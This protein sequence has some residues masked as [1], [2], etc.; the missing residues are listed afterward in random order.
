MPSGL[1][2]YTPPNVVP[3]QRV[4]A[5]TSA[6]FAG[7]P[8]S[9]SASAPTVTVTDSSGSPLAG[10][11]LACDIVEGN[12]TV[13]IAHPVAGANGEGNCGRWQLG[14]AAG[15]NILRVSVAGAALQRSGDPANY[16]NFLGSWNSI[17]RSAS[18]R[19]RHDRR[20]YV[21]RTTEPKAQRRGIS[22]QASTRWTRTMYMQFSTLFGS[23]TAR[24]TLPLG[25]ALFGPPRPASSSGASRIQASR[26]RT[27]GSSQAGTQRQLADG[28]VQQTSI[29]PG[30]GIMRL[31]RR[32]MS[33]R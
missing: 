25:T 19:S 33:R 32:P 15:L 31:P 5:V 10:V 22:W 20:A 16:V 11:M 24:P 2:L 14:S 17:Q 13:A 28:D 23:Q 3:R 21:C 29:A 7:V 4:H 12:G 8:G 30:V 18:L 1:P 26:T 27:R 9:E 6:N